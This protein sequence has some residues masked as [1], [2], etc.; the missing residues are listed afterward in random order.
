MSR[1]S[2]HEL[3]ALSS[4]Q[5]T[6]GLGVLVAL[7]LAYVLTLAVVP[8]LIRKMKAGGMVGKDVNKASKPEVAELGG[9]AALFAFSVSLSLVVG[10]QKLLGNVAEPPFLAAISA[11]FMAAMIGLIDDISNI[12][13]RL[14]AVA[15]A[16]A[17]LTLMLVYLG[18]ETIVL[19]MVLQ[20][21]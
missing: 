5:L 18:S 9:I 7:L 14:K 4:L 1:P 10:L 21:V 12:R 13:Q 2:G 3:V 11:F 16:F 20:S 15:V 8:P 17:T 6:D 19:P